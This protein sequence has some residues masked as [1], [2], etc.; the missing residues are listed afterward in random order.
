MLFLV[1]R[2]WTWLRKAALFS[3]SLNL[4]NPPGLCWTPP[5]LQGLWLRP[6]CRVAS[7]VLLPPLA[8][9]GACPRKQVSHMRGSIWPWTCAFAS[10][11]FVRAH[12]LTEF[13]LVLLGN[14]VKVGNERNVVVH[15]MHQMWIVE[16]NRRHRSAHLLRNIKWSATV[17]GF[18]ASMAQ[19]FVT[20][21][22]FFLWHRT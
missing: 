19:S 21:C 3:P 2:S 8:A 6:C 5:A 20:A 15:V 7:S 16:R 12:T 17:H 4:F 14:R 13:V 11:Q 18:A 1:A 22:S 9:G 10:K